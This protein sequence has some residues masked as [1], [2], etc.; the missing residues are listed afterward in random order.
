MTQERSVRD[1]HRA[2][3]KFT[4]L[5]CA[6][7]EATSLGHGLDVSAGEKVCRQV[8]SPES[9]RRAG[10]TRLLGSAPQPGGH[11]G[12]SPHF[13]WLLLLLKGLLADSWGAGQGPGN[14]P[15]TEP[16]GG[17]CTQRRSLAPGFLTDASSSEHFPILRGDTRTQV[18]VLGGLNS[19]PGSVQLW[20]FGKS[21]ELAPRFPHSHI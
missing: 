20:V 8:K 17:A 16:N 21:R 9:L 7:F 10:G 1:C 18:W 15:R 4:N 3:R 2:L 11:V 14:L 19:S 6:E 13:S 12:A 5:G